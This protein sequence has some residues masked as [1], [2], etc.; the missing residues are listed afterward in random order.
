[1]NHKPHQWLATTLLSTIF[2]AWPY[3]ANAEGAQHQDERGVHRHQTEH[4][5]TATEYHD[6]NRHPEHQG[7]AA[8]Y[9]DSNRHSE[10]QGTAAEYHDSNRYQ[11]H[12]H[13]YHHHGQYY[14]YRHNGSYYN[15]YYQGRYY[16]NCIETPGY[17]SHGHWFPSTMM[18]Q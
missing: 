18:C 6:S 10:H 15:Y 13:Q 9:R 14:N 16:L 5:G 3:V 2:L 4:Q 7:A 11:N 1:M 8:E 12:R 17:W